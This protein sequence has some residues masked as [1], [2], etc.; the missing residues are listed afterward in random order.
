MSGVNIHP[1]PAT[2]LCWTDKS[3][4][5]KGLEMALQPSIHCA[6][7]YVWGEYPSAPHHS[8]LLD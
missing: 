8:A 1:C 2:P 3:S 6:V 7:L 4:S 5:N